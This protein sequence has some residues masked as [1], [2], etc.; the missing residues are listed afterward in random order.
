MWTRAEKRFGMSHR[1]DTRTTA[2]TKIKKKEM[3]VD[4]SKR[5]SSKRAIRGGADA[6]PNTT[7]QN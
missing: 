6:E 4:R 2:A 1:E 5:S 3:S 7:M